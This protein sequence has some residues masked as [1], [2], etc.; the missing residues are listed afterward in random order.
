M[1]CTG[2]SGMSALAAPPETCDPVTQPSLIQPSLLSKMNERQVLRTLQARG[3]L[4]RAEVAR[5][6]GISA[7]T[8]SRAVEALLRAGLLEEG[9]ATG[10]A[11]GRPGKKLRLA[12]S[13]A[14]VL[15]L[16][17]DAGRCRL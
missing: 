13:T 17:I 6:S 3:P 15:G 7:P 11:R 12:S 14:Q 5:H 2:Y 8:A 9:E 10:L 4:S 16:V 1:T